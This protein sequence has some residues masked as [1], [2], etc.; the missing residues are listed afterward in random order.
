[1]AQ[2]V[3]VFSAVIDSEIQKTEKTIRMIRAYKIRP[4]KHKF[5]AIRKKGVKYYRI[6]DK[7]GD[8][9]N[10]KYIG[11]EGSEKFNE[12]FQ[13]SYNEA[14]LVLETNNL[15]V[16]KRIRNQYVEPTTE[17]VKNKLSKCVRDIK[18]CGVFD[19]KMNELIKWT[20]EDYEKNTYKYDD[21]EI[22][23]MDGEQ[24]RSKSECLVSNI[25]INA[26]VPKRHDSILTL[27]NPYGGVDKVSPDFLIRC[28][29]GSYIIHEHVGLLTDE[30]YFEKFVKKLRLYFYNNY[31]IGTNLFFSFDDG[32]GGIDTQT[33][34]NTIETIR[35][36]MLQM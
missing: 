25:F 17:A 6:N 8:T 30:G 23:D 10:R 4:K 22:Y 13:A 18:V 11:K 2:G 33:V 28:F 21:K 16:L 1:M 15:E 31:L 26:G 35:W 34:L 5:C 29:D 19:D 36:R 12:L 32:A 27:D 7:V 14:L 3:F 9:Y 20:K 24:M